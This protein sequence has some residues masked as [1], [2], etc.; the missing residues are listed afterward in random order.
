MNQIIITLEVANTN[1]CRTN[2]LKY[3]E[4]FIDSSY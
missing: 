3:V 4:A 1:E 2:N